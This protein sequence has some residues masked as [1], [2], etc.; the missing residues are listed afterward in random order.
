LYLYFAIA[1]ELIH[2][3]GGKKRKKQVFAL[4][5]DIAIAYY[6][7]EWSFLLDVL[8]RLGFDNKFISLIQACI[9]FTTISINMNG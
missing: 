2:Y 1:S 9:S 5:L 8:A 7:M 6:R 3:M 4:K